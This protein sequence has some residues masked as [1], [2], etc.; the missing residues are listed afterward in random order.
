MGRSKTKNR[1]SIHEMQIIVYTSP[2][3]MITKD[4]ESKL[5]LAKIDD[6]GVF[7]LLIFV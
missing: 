7:L 5:Y 2:F 1:E 4:N 3:P 6:F